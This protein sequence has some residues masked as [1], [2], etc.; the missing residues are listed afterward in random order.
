MQQKGFCLLCLS[1]SI[2]LSIFFSPTWQS[3]CRTNNW[4]S[5]RPC[6]LTGNGSPKYQ[7]EVSSQPDYLRSYKLEALRTV[8]GNVCMHS[9][10]PP[11]MWAFEL[12]FSCSLYLIQSHHSPLPSQARPLLQA[13]Q[14]N[15]CLSSLG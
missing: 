4:R 7:V 11:L 15:G 10:D 14:L 6:T 9:Y 8:P 2:L 13:S 5:L 3:L 12:E 1:V